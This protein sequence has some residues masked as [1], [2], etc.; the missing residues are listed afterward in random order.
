MPIK[1]RR[2]N[3]EFKNKLPR[4]TYLMP[5]YSKKDSFGFFYKKYNIK[6][7]QK[8][9]L[10]VSFDTYSKILDSYNQSLVELL[11]T[12]VK[13]KLPYTLGD[14]QVLKKKYFLDNSDPKYK[15]TTEMFTYFPIVRWTKKFIKIVNKNFYSFTPARSIKLSIKKMF[16]ENDYYKYIIDLD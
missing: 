10:A 12:G 9:K 2:D 14:I 4:K 13:I 16:K 8:H 6:K 15:T 1:K 7:N 3:Y 5:T 11:K